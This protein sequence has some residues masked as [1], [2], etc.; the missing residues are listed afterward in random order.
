MNFFPFT[1]FKLQI[2]LE[3]MKCRPFLANPRLY[4]T[5]D[6]LSSLVNSNIS[7]NLDIIKDR[8]D[9]S[10]R[11]VCTYYL[12]SCGSVKDIDFREISLGACPSLIFWPLMHR[13][14]SH[15]PS[16]FFH[17]RRWLTGGLSLA[18]RRV[19]SRKIYGSWFSRNNVWGHNT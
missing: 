8:N 10:V 1:R 12:G 17:F 5:K 14:F 7:K 13:D 2:S 6:L 15:A 18:R 3:R 11:V 9:V 4:V 16:S 19:V